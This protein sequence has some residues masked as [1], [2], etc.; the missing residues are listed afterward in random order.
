MELAGP[1]RHATRGAG[2][3]ED[4][5]GPVCLGFFQLL[6]PKAVADCQTPLAFQPTCIRI[7]L[8]KT[9]QINMNTKSVE[10]SR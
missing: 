7:V 9:V 2:D 8:V 4:D 10:S 1:L 6:T 3:W 5:E